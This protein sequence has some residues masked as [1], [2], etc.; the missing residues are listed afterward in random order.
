MIRDGK[1]AEPLSLITVAGNL[2]DLFMD[3]KEVS[4]TYA[5]NSH[6]NTKSPALL[7]KKLSITG[8]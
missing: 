5:A 8:K 4:N 6:S 3:V 7:N 1:I 2:F